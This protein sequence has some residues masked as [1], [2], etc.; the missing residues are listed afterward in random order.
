MARVQIITI[1]FGPSMSTLSL[2]FTGLNRKVSLFN[3]FKE[4]WVE[5]K[6]LK[7][8]C[9]LSIIDKLRINYSCNSTRGLYSIKH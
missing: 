2:P 5:L 8:G 7:T 3:C 9:I 1:N 4:L 6:S